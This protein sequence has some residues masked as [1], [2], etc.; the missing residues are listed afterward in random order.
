MRRIALILG[1]ILL[2][3]YSGLAMADPPVVL[4]K[5]KT[6]VVDLTETD[7][8]KKKNLLDCQLRLVGKAPHYKLVY[9]LG[10]IEVPTLAVKVDYDHAAFRVGVRAQISGMPV[11]AL[12]VNYRGSAA[13]LYKLELSGCDLGSTCWAS[14]AY[15]LRVQ[16]PEAVAQ[17]A[18][19][20]KYGNALVLSKKSWQDLELGALIVRDRPNIVPASSEGQAGDKSKK[21]TVVHFVCAT[22]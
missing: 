5:D 11:D 20:A 14:V 1:A 18:L 10:E 16:R 7:L 19:V 22:E 3:L 2:M 6:T 21:S 17:A 4:T 12:T 9:S 15:T 8:V 13:A